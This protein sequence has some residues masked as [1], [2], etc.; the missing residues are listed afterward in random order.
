MPITGSA[1]L[2]MACEFRRSNPFHFCR[3]GGAFCRKTGVPWRL[4][5][6][7]FRV[8]PVFRGF[9]S[10]K[11]LP[12]NDKQRFH[13]SKKNHTKNTTVGFLSVTRCAMIGA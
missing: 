10:C 4:F 11:P 12:F 6:T 7:F 3:N 8:F 2:S 13:L 1:W 5:C 9:Y